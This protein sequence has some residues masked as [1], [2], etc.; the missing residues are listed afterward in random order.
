MVSRPACCTPEAR[1]PGVPFSPP[2]PPPSGALSCLKEGNQGWPETW[3]QPAARAGARTPRRGREACG[4]RAKA[5]APRRGPGPSCVLA[6]PPWVSE[7]PCEHP[8]EAAA[9]VCPQGVGAG[10]S[11]GAGLPTRACHTSP[12]LP[13]STATSL[14][15]SP[16]KVLDGPARSSACHRRTPSG[17]WEKLHRLCHA[18][19]KEGGLLGRVRS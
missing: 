12:G 9:S 8:C 14:S 6:S 11:Q 7:G 16:S 13:I 4:G 5:P 3:G 10:P 18:R 19:Q 2:S 15:P 1:V 17:C